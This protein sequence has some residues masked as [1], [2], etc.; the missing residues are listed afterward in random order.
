MGRRHASAGVDSRSRGRVLGT[1][2]P[3]TRFSRV[4][5]PSPFPLKLPLTVPQT[6]AMRCLE[7]GAS[8]YPAF[9]MVSALGHWHHASSRCRSYL[10][11]SGTSSSSVGDLG[12]RSCTSHDQPPTLAPHPSAWAL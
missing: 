3:V 7:E 4:M 12:A 10:R 5:P 6:H 11:W 8:V 1:R 2:L 9:I